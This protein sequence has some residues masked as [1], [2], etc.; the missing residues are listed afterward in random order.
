MGPLK[1]RTLKN[2]RIHI[3]T[4]ISLSDQHKFLELAE[5]MNTFD[6][7]RDILQPG[8]QTVPDRR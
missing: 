8:P 4:A 2:H 6:D 3:P 1:E 7:I 5:I